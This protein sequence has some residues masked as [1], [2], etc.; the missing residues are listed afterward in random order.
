MTVFADTGFYVALLNPRDRLHG[1]AKRFSS[2]YRGHVVTTEYVLVELGNF[3]SGFAREVFVRFHYQLV[4]DDQTEIVS[5]SSGLLEQAIEVYRSRP[6][7]TWS[8]TD[9]SLFAVMR[10]RN[11]TEALSFDH[12]FDQAG[13]RRLISNA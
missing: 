10:Q 1:A 5:S 13:F 8:L 7:K 4:G 6:D 9:C 3:L 11:I 12:H 2:D